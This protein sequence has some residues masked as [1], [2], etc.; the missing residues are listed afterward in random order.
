MQ[1]SCDYY[2]YSVGDV[3]IP[4]SLQSVSK[5]L[6]YS[7]VLDDLSPEVVH[8]YVGHEPSGVA[9]NSIALNYNGKVFICVAPITQVRHVHNKNSN[10]QGRSNDFPYHNE[11]LLKEGIR[12]PWEQILS[13][14]RSSHFEKGCN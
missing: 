3:T 5:P 13:F 14:K 9:F 6:T 4:F 2:R 10:N 7:L 1:I 12:T 8:Q 11:L